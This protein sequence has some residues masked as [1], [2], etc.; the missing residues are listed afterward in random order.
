MPNFHCPTRRNKT[1]LM[2]QVQRCELGIKQLPFKSRTPFTRILQY[3]DF[4]LLSVLVTVNI[5][6]L[7]T[8][9]L[10]SD[11]LTYSSCSHCLV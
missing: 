7:F 4:L 5:N 11:V 2:R 8:F 10:T 6:N 9:I 3:L 1:V